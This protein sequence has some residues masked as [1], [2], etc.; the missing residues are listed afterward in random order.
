[1]VVGLAVRMAQSLGLDIEDHNAAQ[2]T[3]DESG[4]RQHVWQ[5]CVF[6]DRLVLLTLSPSSLKATTDENTE[7]FRG[8]V[9]VL[10][11]PPCPPQPPQKH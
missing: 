8:S 6:M 10:R 9:L 2:V 5:C 3:T 7:A 4:L 1:M 11:Q